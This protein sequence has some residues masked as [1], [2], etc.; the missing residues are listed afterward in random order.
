M[1]TI[2]FF[3]PVFVSQPQA[4]S[5]APLNLSDVIERGF[6]E[7]GDEQRREMA[8]AEPLR[9]EDNHVNVSS[10]T[11]VMVSLADPMIGGDAGGNSSGNAADTS[12]SSRCFP[13]A[14]GL[15]LS[16][17]GCDRMGELFL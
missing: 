16:M 10:S 11:V 12:I 13:W 1:L 3:P 15:V 14:S 6:D 9:L 5:R 4:R 7:Q 17:V 2:S 8:L